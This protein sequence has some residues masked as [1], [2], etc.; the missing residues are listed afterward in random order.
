[1]N[2]ETNL[3]E[4][5]DLSVHFRR[6][7]GSPV[8]RAVDQVSFSVAERETLG[9][10]GESGSGKTTIGRAVLG[11]ESP[12]DGRIEFAGEDITRADHNRRRALS[13]DLQVIFQDPYSSLNPTRT[14]AQTLGESL[15]AEK[16]AGD[17]VRS[18]VIAMLERVGLPA[19]AADRYPSG[20]SGGQRQ[21]IA[22]ARALVAQPRLVI[23]DEPVSA[24]DLSVQAQVLNL[25]RELQDEFAL[26]YL[27]VAHDLDVVR[28]LSHRI[29]VLYRGQ[30][31]EQGPAEAVYSRPMHPY[32]RTLLEAAP[33]P[34]PVR[35][36]A[37]RLRRVRAGDNTGPVSAA[38]CP[39]ATRCP[40]AA[41]LCHAERPPLEQTPA[42]TTVACHRWQEL[43]TAPTAVAAGLPVSVA[44]ETTRT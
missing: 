5:R 37:H 31:M 42:G 26:G 2:D 32:T 44:S 13:R 38:G 3:L 28:H 20:F 11:L 34:D 8:L 10:V 17:E 9:V 33:V 25:L 29:M 24:L 7:H 36:A 12:T 16:L 18:R 27:F 21:R 6:G 15:R 4:V 41:P 39:F 19:T 14:V 35:Q 40:H 23:C 22:I 43:G 1:V 30:I